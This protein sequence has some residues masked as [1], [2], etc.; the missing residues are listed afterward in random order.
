MNKQEFV[1]LVQS[2]GNYTTKTQADKAIKSVT[3]AI[4]NALATK[5]SVALMG[6]CTFT[7]V[8]VPEK[9]GTVPGTDKTYTKAA[10]TAPKF[11]AG[12]TLK[13]SVAKASI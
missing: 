2:V 9:S 13:D 10:H 12:Q 7:A 6:F 1:E 8:D 5:E 11:K 3:E 4:T